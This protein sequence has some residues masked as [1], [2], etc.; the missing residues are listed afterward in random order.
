MTAVQDLPGPLSE[1]SATLLRARRFDVVAPRYGGPVGDRFPSM[2]A[3]ELRRVLARRPLDYSSDR[4]AGSH[5]TLTSAAG[6]PQLVFA[7]HDG[8][9]ISPGLVR[10]ILVKDVGLSLEEARRLL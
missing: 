1:D 2:K 7:F 4:T 8:E 3:R 5:E 6:Y 10:K 9:T